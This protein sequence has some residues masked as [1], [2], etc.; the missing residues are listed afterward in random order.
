MDN[1]IIGGR[2]YISSKRAAELMG[3]TQDYI[4][5]LC[6]TGKLPAERVSGVWYVCESEFEGKRVQVSSLISN[7]SSNEKAN[8][9][10]TKKQNRSLMLDGKEYISS[11]R[12][13]ELMGYTQDYIG[14]LCRTGKIEARQVGRGWYI[15]SSVVY[16]EFKKVVPKDTTF[17]TSSTI[18]PL[19]KKEDILEREVKEQLVQKAILTTPTIYTQDS[20]PL[21]PELKRMRRPVLHEILEDKAED[22]YSNNIPIRRVPIR[23]IRIAPSRR[24]GNQYSEKIPTRKSTHYRRH[25]SLSAPGIAFVG[26]CML[27]LSVSV[28]IAPHRLVFKAEEGTI[29]TVILSYTLN[30]KGVHVGTASTASKNSFLEG[31]TLFFINLFEEKIEYKAK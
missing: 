12:A 31:L 14:Q 8:H 1:I 3:Y 7:E 13:A 20:N 21:M 10:N 26:L 2:N 27:I 9:L 4:G 6:R 25:T 28:S 5:Q 11:K 29:S 19:L 18:A 22:P 16:A 17:S 30:K 24:G 15:P 23:T